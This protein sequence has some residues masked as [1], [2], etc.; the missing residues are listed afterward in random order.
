M[1][2]NQHAGDYITGGGAGCSAWIRLL[3]H[4]FTSSF[5]NLMTKLSRS[6]D[7][8]YE[9]VAGEAILINLK[10]GVYYSLNEVGTLF[11]NMLDGQRTI[12]DCAQQIAADYEAPVETVTND[13]FELA[14][15]LVKENLVQV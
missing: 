3:I 11:W 1:H 6:L 7:A 15:N 5:M 12:A 2:V 9:V 4:L 10:T 8:S 13:L 14:Q